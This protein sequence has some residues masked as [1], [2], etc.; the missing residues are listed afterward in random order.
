MNHAEAK[1]RITEL[2]D[3]IRRHDHLYY[4]DGQT[5]ISDLEYDKLY[6][7][8]KHLEEQH[9]DL[10]TPDSP[11]QRVGTAPV[12]GFKEVPHLI[13]M[14]S[15][16]KEDTLDGL[17][18]FD[19][20]VRKDLPGEIVKYVLEP[21]V[22]GVSISVRYEN[23]NLT[24]GLDRG[25]G[26]KG[27][28]ITAN[29]KTI[30]AIPLRLPLKSPPALLEVRGEAYMT[31]DGFKLYCQEELKGL[32][33]EAR[34]KR[35]GNL[36][37]RN[38][39]N[40]TLHQLDPR[41]VARRKL[42]AVFYAVGAL[43]GTSFERH[44]EVLTKLREWGF[45][46]PRYWRLCDTMEEVLARFEDE[47]VCHGD[48]SRD[49]RTKLPY[50]LDGIVVKLDDLS[51]W[52]RVKGTSKTPGYAIV[53]KPEHWIEK[54]ET[55]LLDIT[56]QVG[57]TG[58]LT[59]VAELAPVVVQRSTIRRA[60]LHNEEEIRRKDIRIGDTVIVR[61]A[62][63]VIPEVVRVVK[64]KRT[65][66]EKEFKMPTKCPVCA[67]P[68]HRDPRFLAAVCHNKVSKTRICGFQIHDP[69]YINGKCPKC[70]AE[71][72][73]DAQYV[74]W[75]CGNISCPAQLKRSVQHFA[76]R[77]AMDI[78][79]L[80]EVIVEALVDG[81][82]I[83]DVADIYSLTKGNIDAVVRE[84][85]EKRA[86]WRLIRN[87]LR[88]KNVKL[89]DSIA[90][91]LAQLFEN[92]ENLTAAKSDQLRK[93]LH[94]DHSLAETIHQFFHSG[95]NADLIKEYRAQHEGLAATN[96]YTAIQTSKNRDLW[97]LI[98][99]LGI[100]EVGEEASRKL[101]A[102]FGDLEKISSAGMDE[103]Q[104]VE[105]TG[106]VMAA[107]IHDFFHNQ[108][109]Q[110]VIKELRDHGLKMKESQVRS[111]KSEGP[112]AGKTVVVTGTLSKLSR[113]EAKE[114]LRKAGATVTDSVSKKT[115]YLIVGEDAGSKLDKA[116]K[117]GVKTLTEQEFSEKLG[118]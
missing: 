105:D 76:M 110:A 65:G 91:D 49:L 103:L 12:E 92:F 7:E 114:R 8:L 101:A 36:N 118:S 112:F 11:T 33:G 95:E 70:G 106:P 53:Y 22:D 96:L 85:D 18:K 40:G 93:A 52:N 61:K 6:A 59:P 117:L 72:I 62:G 19:I 15:L 27:R 58:V 111:Q 38:A 5:E 75:I 104:K 86:F 10:I 60:T 94:G 17:K 82:L 81:K 48:E 63:M 64:E 84:A 67:G 35:E 21:K 109:N 26:E 102:H 1:R 30:R 32:K 83:K 98:H 74:D 108:R 78:E 2:R 23:G 47:V 97:R 66:K 42:R 34:E 43:G 31:D 107:S 4:G 39:C 13:P 3:Q 71:L 80:G 73:R 29:L 90:R 79:G 44:S 116:Q 24:L 46:T 28:D 88:R 87:L 9:L 25:D 14:M 50:E 99:G 41:I 89:D 68:V 56:V 100:P 57:R 37:K 54:R 77:R 51:Q 113:Q 69:L 20:N 45:P 55:K 16:N 115:D